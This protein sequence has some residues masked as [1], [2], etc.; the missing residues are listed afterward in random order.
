MRSSRLLITVTA[1][2]RA[3]DPRLAIII[4]LGEFSSRAMPASI[5][6]KAADNARHDDIMSQ[7]I[8]Y[9]G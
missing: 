2:W 3:I 7:I 4:R 8:L 6:R 1:N 5:P 9:W